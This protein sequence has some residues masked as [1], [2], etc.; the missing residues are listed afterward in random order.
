MY[1]NQIYKTHL[2]ETFQWIDLTI[3][4]RKIN[5][6]FH[7]DQLKLS[8][9]LS[10]Q[11][12]IHTP[13]LMYKNQIYKTHLPETFQWIDLTIISRKINLLF[14]VDQIKLSVLLSTQNIIHTPSLISCVQLI[15]YK[16]VTQNRL[17]FDHICPNFNYGS[18]N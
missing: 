10:T 1:K 16:T 14:H 4:S 3:I 11:N 13:S 18:I 8:V 6:L 5:L 2:P 9:L 7:V 12:I 17:Y 15:W